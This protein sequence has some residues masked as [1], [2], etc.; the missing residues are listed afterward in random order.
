MKTYLLRLDKE[1]LKK[2]KVDSAT[3]EISMR[4]YIERAIKAYKP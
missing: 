3:M 1:L 2:V 4:E